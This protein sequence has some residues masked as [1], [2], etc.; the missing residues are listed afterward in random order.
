[1]PNWCQNILTVTDS[2]N[3][4]KKYL[5]KNGFYFEKIKPTPKKLL[6]DKDDGWYFWR[7]Q[8]WGTKWDIENEIDSITHKENN[9]LISFNTAWSP[10]IP[11]IETLSKMFPAATFE[12]KYF[13]G[14]MCFG[15]I[16][17]IKD[18]ITSD[19]EAD[20]NSLEKF[21]KLHMHL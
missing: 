21:Q 2:S 10:P 4:V 7:I 16:A 6:D 19:E 12:L 18:G 13:E 3:K 20:K 1:M 5:R 14:G 15:G 17:T 8:N 11:L 9:V